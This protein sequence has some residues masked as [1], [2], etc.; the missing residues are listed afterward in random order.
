MLVHGAWHGVWCW[1][2][3]VER[4]RAD[5]VPVRT[6]ELRS[7]GEADGTLGDLYDDA[8]AV[9][10][11]L[12]E[13]D[14]PVVVVAHSYGGAPVTEGAAGAANVVHIVY[15][16]AFTPDVGESLL[17]LAHGNEP[18]WWITAPDGRTMLPDDPESLFYNDCTPEVSAAA[19]ARIRPH[20]KLTVTQPIRS[21]AWREI[22]TTYVVCERDQALPPPV[23]EALAERAGA[24]L[25]LDTGHSPFLSRPDDLVAIVR[26]VMPA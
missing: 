11:V 25:R 15:V 20:N 14:G 2:A 5:G 22:P 17:A 24:V 19:A 3:V 6:V 23:Q 7:V 18:E 21:V 26:D 13:I 9:R 10:S 4:L 8:A 16:A 1:E 12:D